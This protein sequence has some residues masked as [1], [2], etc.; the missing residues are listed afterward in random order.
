MNTGPGTP[1]C[2]SAKASATAG[3]RSRTRRI[4]RKRLTCGS[5]S[6]RWS[7]SCSAPRPCSAVGAAPPISTTGDCASCA[8]FSAV[9]VLVMPGPAVTAATPG[10]PDSRALASAAKTAVT[11]SRTSTTRMPRAL[12]ALRIGEMWPPHSVK[13]SRHAVGLQRLGDAVA[14]VALRLQHRPRVG[15]AHA[16]TTGLLPAYQAST[17]GAAP[18]SMRLRLIFIVGVRQPFSMRPGFAG[19]HDHLQL[20]VVGHAAR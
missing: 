8:F 4:F 14:A 9:M 17:C 7:M 20:L 5:T 2:A 6:G 10:R 19:D 15:T 16:H 3:P 13:T 11:S 1:D 12:D 18:S